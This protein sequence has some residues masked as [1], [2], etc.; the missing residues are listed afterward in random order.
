MS[1]V[2]KG[3]PGH[4]APYRT[5]HVR[6]PEPIKAAVQEMCDDFKRG[7]LIDSPVSES[8]Q[9]P[10]IQTAI[11]VLTDA[12]DLKANAGGKIKIKIREALA[13]LGEK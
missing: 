5:T 8:K 12:L 3:G 4:R 13:I 6:V 1:I 7:A 9:A 2:W 11:A 10:D